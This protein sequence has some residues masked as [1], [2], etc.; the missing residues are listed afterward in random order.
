MEC[1]SIA[2]GSDESNKHCF[3]LICN[4]L[5]RS[6]ISAEQQPIICSSINDLGISNI[7]GYSFPINP[8]LQNANIPVLLLSNT[9]SG[10]QLNDALLGN[11]I[12]ADNVARPTFVHHQ[13]PIA[14]A[15]NFRQF[16]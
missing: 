13:H 7:I 12:A 8:L 1:W 5:T 4:F 14:H 15:D 3:F 10:S 9:H 2:F 16:R 6:V 11:L